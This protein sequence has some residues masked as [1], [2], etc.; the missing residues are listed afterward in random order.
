MALQSDAIRN[1]MQNPS[2]AHAASNGRGI[3]RSG[4]GGSLVVS[5]G[6]VLKGVVTDIHGKQITIQM[7]DGTSFSGQLADASNYSIGQGAAFQVTGTTAGVIY[8][9]ATGDAYLL[10]LE[11]TISQALEEA[12]LPKS[13]RNV[14][15]V[16]SLLEGRQSISRQS[17]M[18]TIQL[19]AKFP[20]NNVN[21]VITAKNLSLPM[22][23]Q[24]ISQLE[25]YQNQTH[26]LLY[27]MDT[28]TNSIN[29]VLNLIGDKAPNVASVIGDKILELALESYGLPE[30]EQPGNL[31]TDTALG[32]QPVSEET[33]GLTTGVATE[34]TAGEI[35]GG[36][37]ISEEIIGGE[38]TGE[39]IAS[40]ENAGKELTDGEVSDKETDNNHVV[41]TES[42]V[43]NSSAGEFSFH[44]SQLGSLLNTEARAHL[45]DLI[46]H[47]PLSEEIK[48]AVTNGTITSKDFLST[49]KDA[50]SNMSSDDAAAIIS[51]KD[52]QAILKEQLMNGWSMTPRS[53]AK[54]EN[55]D[56]LYEKLDKQLTTLTKLSQSVSAQSA[57]K[58]LNSA[59]SDMQGNLQFMKTLNDTFSYFQLP[60]RLQEENAHGDLYVMTK[61]G[62][63]KNNPDKLSVLLHLEMEH[64]GE[65][66]IHIK[67]DKSYIET[68]FYLSEKKT[69]HL[70]E[71]NI[72]LLRNAINEQGYSFT[73]EF[74]MK[75][76][77]LDI[78]KDFIAQDKPIGDMKRYNFDLRA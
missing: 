1:H 28:L 4:N 23:E 73:S 18:D 53:F 25:Q 14:E 34:T 46:N 59:A 24:S 69:R 52:F 67:K 43:N 45:S 17:I 75:E 72:E 2:M 64:L 58:E 37:I 63:L 19:C 12:A 35:T 68:K 38:N 9:Q 36:E 71:T 6:Q 40:G 29:Q 11:D 57:F 5:E 78:V 65:L 70:L 10:G 61:K 55:I 32:G 15:I 74:S 44:K 54:K 49:I 60:L 42:G 66:D 41:N 21:A 3:I 20:N 16:R 56:R 76:K 26:Q 51:D 50:L 39:K 13:P 62:A 77:D 30:D 47:L 8:M 7:N 33:A 48:Q 31:S 22:T 27:K